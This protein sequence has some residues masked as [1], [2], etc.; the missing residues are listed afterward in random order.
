MLYAQELKESSSLSADEVRDQVREALEH[1]TGQHNS[2]STDQEWVEFR[3]ELPHPVA[4]Y[5]RSSLFVDIPVAMSQFLTH[6]FGGMRDV[7]RKGHLR[8]A[9]RSVLFSAFRS[10]FASEGRISTVAIV[11]GKPVL[12][13]SKHCLGHG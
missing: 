9:A 12:L 10:V 11:S 1:W 4:V 5:T 2:S 7:L 13:H 8:Y 6:D 3:N